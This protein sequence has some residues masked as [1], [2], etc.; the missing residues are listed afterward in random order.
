VSIVC[1]FLDYRRRVG[2]IGP[3]V[4]PT[5]DVGADMAIL[6]KFYAPI[7]G[8]YPQRTTPVRLLEKTPLAWHSATRDLVCFESLAQAAGMMR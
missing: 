3:V 5:G 4:T 8:R 2:G 6:R 7:V 1:A